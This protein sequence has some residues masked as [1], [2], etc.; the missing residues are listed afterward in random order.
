M[1]A[2]IVAVESLAVEQSPGTSLFDIDARI[3]VRATSAD[4]AVATLIE[5]LHP[6]P[7]PW[8]DGPQ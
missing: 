3:V 4:E 2:Q 7:G 5:S 6:D 1:N 8:T